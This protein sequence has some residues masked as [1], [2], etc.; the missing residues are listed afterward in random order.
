[1]FSCGIYVHVYAFGHLKRIGR[2]E[3]TSK[4]LLPIGTIAESK[5]DVKGHGRVGLRSLLNA[6]NGGVSRVLRDSLQNQPL[7]ALL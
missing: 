3:L 1:M 5:H 6:Q 7:K 2:V 4:P